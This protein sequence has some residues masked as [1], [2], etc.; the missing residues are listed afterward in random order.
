MRSV[1][2]HSAIRRSTSQGFTLL[3]LVV[4]VTILSVVFAIALPALGD[5][6]RRWRLQGAVREV[7][8]I[9]KFA[10]NQSVA[11]RASLQVVLDRSRNVYWLDSAESGLQSTLDEVREKGIRLYAMPAGIHLG[12]VAVAGATTDVDRAGIMFFPRGNA[13]AAEIEVRD[14]KGRRYMISVD[15]MTGHARIGR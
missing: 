9:L 14:E 1:S 2:E 15:S 13:T 4:V 11:G 10:R 7:A 12:E 8:T 6:L 3:E 5:G